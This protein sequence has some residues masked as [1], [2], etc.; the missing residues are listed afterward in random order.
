MPLPVKNYYS[1][2]ATSPP[3][4]NGVAGALIAV[5]DAGLV[6]GWGAVAV[7]SIAVTANVATITTSTNHNFAI[8]DNLLLSGANEAAFNGEFFVKAVTGSTTFTVDCVTALTA[9]TGTM[10]VKIAP[11]GWEKVFAGTNLAVYRSADVTGTRL[12]LR[13]NDTTTTYATVA[14]YETM[15]DINT[16]TGKSADLYWAKSDAA[17]STTR[18]WYLIGDSKRFYFLPAYFLNNPAALGCAFGDCNSYKAGDAFHTL[19]IG[20]TATASAYSV[21][22]FGS[23]ANAS[24]TAGQLLARAYTQ[25]GGT[26]NFYKQG[27]LAADVAEMGYVTG[28][29]AVNPGDNGI[30]LTP[31]LIIEAGGAN[32]RGA[33]PG[34][35]APLESVGSAF[36]SR[37]R[38]LIL[39]GKSY[40]AF[41][42]LSQ[43]SSNVSFSGCCWFDAVGPW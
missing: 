18:P 22:S 11:L 29:P 35:Y 30:H 9:A 20:Q 4:L 24:K 1:T 8:G 12:Y 26:V 7:S 28:L 31:L 34:L 3:Q 39:A 40:L 33:M 16:G 15:T 14:M 27:P 41:Q 43:T 25:L 32:L 6:T 2:Q 17:N 5:L 10:S 37:D 21:S 42:T 38:S 23:V 36:A 13:V 19:L